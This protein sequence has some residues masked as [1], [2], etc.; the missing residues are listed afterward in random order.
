[1][2]F[3]DPTCFYNNS[4]MLL[5]YEWMQF[6][7][8]LFDVLSLFL[9]WWGLSCTEHL[10]C[11]AC[12]LLCLWWNFVKYGCRTRLS[13]L[14]SLVVRWRVLF[15]DM[16]WSVQGTLKRRRSPSPANYP[17]YGAY[18]PATSQA[19]Y[20]SEYINYITHFRGGVCVRLPLSQH[21]STM[22]SCT[23]YKC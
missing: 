5:E 3:S 22:S 17:Q 10:K 7:F 13:M 11:L 18:K 2:C 23:H 4:Q 16:L 9:A 20:Q 6:F 15:I 1:M 19:S 21:V 14:L 12:L 8:W